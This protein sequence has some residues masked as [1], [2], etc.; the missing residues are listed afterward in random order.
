MSSMVLQRLTTF[1]FANF[2]CAN[3]KFTAQEYTSVALCD[4]V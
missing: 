1:A 4:L 2:E 3:V